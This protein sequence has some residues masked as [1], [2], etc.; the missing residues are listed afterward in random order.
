MLRISIQVHVQMNYHVK[1]EHSGACSN[2][3]YTSHKITMFLYEYYIYFLGLT[4]QTFLKFKIIL[5]LI[6]VFSI[7]LYLFNMEV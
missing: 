2:G 4:D 7:S 1:N 3:F 6:L 5:E